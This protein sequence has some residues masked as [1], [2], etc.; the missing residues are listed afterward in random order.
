MEFKFY[1]LPCRTAFISTD[2]EFGRFGG[3]SQAKNYYVKAKHEICGAYN[4][5]PLT[6]RERQA[7]R[8]LTGGRGD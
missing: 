6:R 7:V 4:Y 2:W 1:C 3:K 8:D 5:K